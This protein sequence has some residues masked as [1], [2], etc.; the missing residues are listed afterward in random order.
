MMVKGRKLK[1]CAITMNYTSILE[2]LY[3]CKIL[4]RSP[5][6]SDLSQ[7]QDLQNKCCSKL[8]KTIDI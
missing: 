7:K 8:E 2:R 4:G 5:S 6:K 1:N 3:F